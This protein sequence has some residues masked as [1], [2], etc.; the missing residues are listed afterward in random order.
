MKNYTD[1]PYDDFSG[2]AKSLIKQAEKAGIPIEPSADKC[3]HLI[4]NDL[5]EA[6]PPQLYALMAKI[7]SAMEN[8]AAEGQNSHISEPKNK[9]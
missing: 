4:K 5:R 8:L 7:S 9:V 2:V 3:K 1:Q 6:I